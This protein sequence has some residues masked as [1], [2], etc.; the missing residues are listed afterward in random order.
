LGHHPGKL[1]QE[2]LWMIFSNVK[3]FKTPL[4]AGIFGCLRDIYSEVLGCEQSTEAMRNRW[5]H[6]FKNP[7]PPKVVDRKDA[8]CKEVAIEKEK[9][10][11]M[12]EKNFLTESGRK[13]AKNIFF[14]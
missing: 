1:Q 13:L 6:I 9:L 8:P 12:I 2:R 10:A 14:K 3:G 7:L 4:V 11:A 5:Q